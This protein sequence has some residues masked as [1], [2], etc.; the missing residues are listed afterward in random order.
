MGEDRERRER[1]I[2]HIAQPGFLRSASE[3]QT[4][5]SKL[6]EQ[7][8][9]GRILVAERLTHF[10]EWQQ[11]MMRDSRFQRVALGGALFHYERWKDTKTRAEGH[12]W[13]SIELFQRLLTGIAIEEAVKPDDLEALINTLNSTGE[14]LHVVFKGHSIKRSETIIDSNTPLSSI[15]DGIE[16]EYDIQKECEY[17][18]AAREKPRSRH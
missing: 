5:A 16:L 14:I 6:A 9:A 4:D 18:I 1:G 11:E 12:C 7:T 17:R 13:N 2:D 3:V 10:S 8:E 15:S